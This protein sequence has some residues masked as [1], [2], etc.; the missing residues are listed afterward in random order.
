MF[1]FKRKYVFEQSIIKKRIISFLIMLFIFFM[2]PYAVT[3]AVTG[4]VPENISDELINGRSISVKYKHAYKDTDINK[5]IVMVL[6]D[7]L[8]MSS[9]VEVIKAEAVMVRT[10]IYRIMG[11]DMKIDSDKLGIQYMTT[12]QMKNEWGDD[13][14]TNYNLISDCVAATGNQVITY[15]NRLIEAKYT[16]LS[17]GATLSGEQILGS[18][19]SYLAKVEC[20]E[21][22]KS[23]DFLS[24]TV[25]QEKDFLKKMKKCYKDIGINEDDI[26]GDIQIVSK[27]EDGYILK[28]Q[29]GNVIMTGNNFAQNLGLNS[30]CMSIEEC[31]DGIKFTTKGKGDGFGVSINTADIM[32]SQ[33]STYNEIL[34]KFYSDTA[35]TNQ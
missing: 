21:D 30:S 9:S 32:A 22:I 28:I 31:S 10:D 14:E 34:A 13:Y 7:R 18:D 17:N 4:V 2:I 3:M 12:Q 20:P 6:A 8:N 16:W 1:K 19:Y 33:G 11:D 23:S 29:V 24:V 5:F 35:I 26:L 25:M 27:T 15:N